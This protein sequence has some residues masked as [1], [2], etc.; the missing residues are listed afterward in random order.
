MKLPFL[1]LLGAAALAAYVAKGKD[2]L[3][4]YK[5]RFVDALFDLPAIKKDNFK[6]VKFGLRIEVDNPTEFATTLQSADLN[7]IHD[8]KS[9]G[10]IIIDKPVNIEAK[11]KT[12]IV[13]PV[14]IPTSKVVGNITDI[15]DLIQGKG[16]LSFNLAGKMNFKAGTLNV[17]ELY[18]VKLK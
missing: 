7:V 14:S 13:L 4:K 16:S 6:S 15:I 5:V 1:L 18:K 8:K 11:K 2:F 9:M 10:K 12:L 3:Q 17:N